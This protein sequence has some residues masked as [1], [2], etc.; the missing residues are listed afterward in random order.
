MSLDLN[1]RRVAAI[2][3]L[4]NIST[5]EGGGRN[6]EIRLDCLQVI[7][8]RDTKNRR[9][10]DEGVLSDFFFFFLLEYLSAP[11]FSTQQENSSRA[12]GQAA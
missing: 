1:R 9:M 12:S 10:K 6:T 7:R 4:A 8:M 2:S 3:F 5:E 11:G